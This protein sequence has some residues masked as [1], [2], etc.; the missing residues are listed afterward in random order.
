MVWSSKVGK[1]RD[2]EKLLDR[3]RLAWQCT[4]ARRRLRPRPHAHRRREAFD[5]AKRTGIDIWQTEDLSG[6]DRK[7]LS[8]TPAA[9]ASPTASR[10]R[11]PT[12]ARYRFRIA[13]FDAV[14]SS[15]AI[16][17]NLYQRKDRDEGD[18]RDRPG[19]EARRPLLVTTSATGGNMRRSFN[20]P[21][22]R[23]W[24]AL[25]PP[26]RPCSWASSPGDRSGRRPS[27]SGDRKTSTNRKRFD[28]PR[29]TSRR[30][31]HHGDCR[32]VRSARCK[33]G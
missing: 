21:A 31:G 26:R 24:R 15:R 18:P 8:K 13:S 25:A 30:G 12:C 29:R 4:G 2:R 11:Q 17:Q 33:T 6:I 3:H 27:S 16:P 10:S 20:P 32:V 1:I 28:G 14:V 9:K 5:S 7:P 23:R 22:A 19:P